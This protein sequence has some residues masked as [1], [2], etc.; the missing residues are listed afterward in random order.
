MSGDYA[1]PPVGPVQRVEAFIRRVLKIDP[2]KDVE[3]DDAAEQVAQEK[4]EEELPP[5]ERFKYTAADPLV[6]KYIDY[7]A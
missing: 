2:V 1:I 5:E 3:R 6:G 4:I 7:L